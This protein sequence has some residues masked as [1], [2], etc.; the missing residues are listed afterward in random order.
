MDIPL[1]PEKKALQDKKN[2]ERAE[3]EALERVRA[4]KKK[5]QEKRKRRKAGRKGGEP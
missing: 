2:R 4:A 3:Q 5:T 1:S